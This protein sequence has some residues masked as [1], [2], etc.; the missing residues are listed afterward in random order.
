[1][2]LQELEAVVVDVGR[3]VQEISGRKWNGVGADVKPI[4]D[5]DGFD[6]L[7]GVEATVMI[8]KKLDCEL[9]VDSVFISSDG[10]RSLTTL[11]IAEHLAALLEGT[12][13][14]Q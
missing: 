5:L 8:E 2:N 9:R 10:N 4:G 1:M 13:C 14:K 3:E 6:S 7:T 12:G 11:E